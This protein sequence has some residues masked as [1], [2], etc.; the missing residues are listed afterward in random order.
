MDSD[1]E[2][3]SEEIHDEVI[4]D[5]EFPSEKGTVYA[6][7]RVEQGSRRIDWKVGHINGTYA[8]GIDLYYDGEELDV[9]PL[10]EM[11]ENGPLGMYKDSSFHELLDGETEIE[12]GK[13]TVKKVYDADGIDAVEWA[14]G[15]VESAF[16][17]ET[18]LDEWWVVPSSWDGAEE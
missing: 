17:A 15:K 8:E 16:R 4:T 6:V 5:I 11:P 13:L 10:T 9:S 2:T 1:S 12:D 14:A 18:I 3:H 7:R